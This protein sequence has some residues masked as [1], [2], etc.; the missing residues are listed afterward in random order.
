MNELLHAASSVDA[1]F[2]ATLTQ[3]FRAYAVEFGWP[4]EVAEQVEMVV[5]DGSVAAHFHTVEPV[6]DWELGTVGRG[7]LPAVRRYVAN[8]DKQIAQLYLDEHLRGFHRL[9]MI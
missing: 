7:P 3:R 6:M 2:S 8:L 4:A 1:Q 5:N 9:G